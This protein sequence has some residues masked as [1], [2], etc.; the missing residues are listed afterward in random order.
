MNYSNCFF[1]R[2]VQNY[3]CK[4]LTSLWLANF[5]WINAMTM[6]HAAAGPGGIVQGVLNY[7]DFKAG[8]LGILDDITDPAG[9][10]YPPYVQTFTFPVVDDAVHTPGI[11]GVTVYLKNTATNAL[12]S[13]VITDSKGVFVFPSQ[14]AGTYALCWSSGLPGMTPGCSNDP[15]SISYATFDVID[16]TSNRWVANLGSDRII[17]WTPLDDPTKNILAFE[18]YVTANGLPNPYAPNLN[19]ACSHSD[20]FFQQDE[21]ATVQLLNSANIVLTKVRANSLGRF[22]ITTTA[23]TV[24]S[25]FK[26]VAN[27]GK[28]KVSIPISSVTQGRFFETLTLPGNISPTITSLVAV[29]NTA[30][31]SIPSGTPLAGVPLGTVVNAIAQATD[32]NSDVLA[33]V[34]KATAGTVVRTG[35]TA[36]WTLPSTGKGLHFL[37]VDVNDNKGGHSSSRIA[38]STD[39]GFI[40]ATSPVIVKNPADFYTESDRFLTYR[41][42]DTKKSACQYYKAIG[43]VKN[44]STAGDLIGGITFS[45]WLTKFGLNA[46]PSPYSATPPLN[47]GEFH[48]QFRNVADLNLIRNHHGRNTGLDV[49]GKDHVGYYVCNHAKATGATPDTNLVACVNMEYSVT[50]GQNDGKPFTK[51]LTFGPTGQL[52]ASVNLDGR[53]EKY[54]PGNCVPCHGGDNYFHHF[55]ET[56]ASAHDGNIGSYF[57]PFDL[58]NFIYEVPYTKAAQQASVRNLNLGLKIGDMLTSAGRELVDGWYPS[59]TGSQISTFLPKGWDPKQTP[60]V[61]VLGQ[62]DTSTGSGLVVATFN[63]ADLYQKVVKPSC[64]G[65]HLSMGAPLGLDFHSYDYDGINPGDFISGHALIP[66]TQL[67]DLH[68]YK[69]I[70]GKYIDGLPNYNILEDLNSPAKTMPNAIQTFNRYWKD[71]VQTGL[72][73]KY[74][75][76]RGYN[77]APCQVPGK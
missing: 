72:M 76:E 66:R 8:P 25:N 64:R 24:A 51:F 57:V 9:N 73:Q 29:S 56:G 10:A 69:V 34:W 68:T 53:G 41:G 45:Q 14:A 30:Q 12:T 47:P 49:N 70:C 38:L 60:T 74:L 3:I 28:N 42:I 43:A 62:V 23:P 7:P 39:A 71:P 46:P 18:G 55:P 19:I 50:P 44:C 11:P 16:N 26:L 2:L 65:C 36:T 61:P 52:I 13:S 48:A 63:G 58:D 37:Y 33:Y 54:T 31:G 75:I 59:G 1:C 77:S 67:N 35:N 4:L 5:I 6:A 20:P 22:L 21:T 32:T 15:S 17:D 40:A 27:C